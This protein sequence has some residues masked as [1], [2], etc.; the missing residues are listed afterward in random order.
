A[1]EEAWLVDTRPQWDG[2]AA[3]VESA[4]RA[5]GGDEPTRPLPGI[6][7]VSFLRRLP[8]LDHAGF[9]AAWERHAGLARRHHPVLWRYT[10]NMVVRPLTPTTPELDGI[11]D[12]TMRL[13]QDFVDRMYDSP[14]GRRIIGEDV[15]G[16]I[17]VPA[18]WRLHAREYRPR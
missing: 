7:Q 11:A 13:R 18:G 10:Q 4:G 5:A 9:V 17:D 15:R 12:L 3:G 1:T 6:K 16:F 8:T 14:E 2:L